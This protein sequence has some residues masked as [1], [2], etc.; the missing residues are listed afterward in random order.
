MKAKT[1]CGHCGTVFQTDENFLGRI[2]RCPN[3]RQ[4]F[5]MTPFEDQ[6]PAD[7][8]VLVCPKCKFTADIP[9]VTSK[10]KLQCQECGHRFVAGPDPQNRPGHPLPTE[11]APGEGGSKAPALLLLILLLA[12]AAMLA[13]RLFFPDLLRDLGIPDLLPF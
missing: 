2:A 13:G 9:R 4:R 12:V 6:P 1:R 3:C 7:T 10:L 11:K 8:Q 5:T